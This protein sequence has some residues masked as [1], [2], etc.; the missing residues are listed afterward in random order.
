MFVVAFA[1]LAACGSDEPAADEDPAP[2]STPDDG[3]EAEPSD[4]SDPTGESG[5]TSG[6]D[7]TDAA[8]PATEVGSAA[9]SEEDPTDGTA[10]QRFPDVVDATADFDGS[11]WTVS[12]TLSSPYDTPERYADAW[13][14]VGP[15][16]TVY[17]ERILTHDHANE[18]P[19]TRSQSGI[20]IP[21]DVDVVTI[22]G[23]DQ[24]YGWGG[25]TFELTLDR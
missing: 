8:P 3:P 4:G 10:E 17:G 25:D 19:F 5:K 18:Q 24:Q 11:T 20:E 14:V 2:L 7:D 21:D 9:R 23:R 16:D 1:S 15:D 22:E 6:S 12:A 13:R